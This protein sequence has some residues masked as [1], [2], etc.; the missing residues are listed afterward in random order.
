MHVHGIRL[1]ARPAERRTAKLSTSSMRTT[2]KGLRAAISGTVSVRSRVTLRWLSPSMSLGKACGLISRSVVA[3][4]RASASA[5]TC[6]RPRAIVVL[7]VPA[8]PRAR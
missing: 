5:A 3:P 1:E 8:G 7:P 6:A 4:L 2:V